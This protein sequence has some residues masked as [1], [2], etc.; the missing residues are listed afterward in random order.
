M[1]ISLDEAKDYLDVIHD[2]DDSKL[3]M[4]LDAA[5]DEALQFMNRSDFGEVC[6]CSSSSSSGSVMPASVR[7][8]VLILLQAAYQASPDDAEQLRHVAEVILMPY[9]CGL[10]V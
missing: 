10:G 8:G 4:L 7:L 2:A 6:E 3:Q 9:R 1:T 5:H